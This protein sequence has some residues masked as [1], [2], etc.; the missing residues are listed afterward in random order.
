MVVGGVPIPDDAH[1]EKVA[2]FALDQVQSVSDMT[3]PISGDP[4]RVSSTYSRIFC[5][6]IVYTFLQPCIENINIFRYIPLLQPMIDSK[7]G[8]FR[9]PL[10]R[11][12]LFSTHADF[13][14]YS[15]RTLL[16]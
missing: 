11:S 5:F 12:T 14:V 6:V 15:E 3:S 7:Y 10:I 8:I 13:I 9:D 16:Y 2:G 4:I 1:A